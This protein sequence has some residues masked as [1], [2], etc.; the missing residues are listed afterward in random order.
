MK[1]LS[2]QK[3]KKVNSDGIESPAMLTPAAICP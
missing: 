2:A 1:M 3:N